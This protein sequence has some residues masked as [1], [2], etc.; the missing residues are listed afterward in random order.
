MLKRDNI[1]LR[2]HHLLCLYGF[3]GL[4]YSE[5]FVENM[6]A[7]IDRIRE[8]P[9]IEIEVV[10]GIDDICAKCPHNVENSCSKPRRNVEEFDREIVGRLGIDIGRKVESK[11]LLNLVEK[12]IQPEELPAICKGCEWLELGFCEEGLRKKNWSR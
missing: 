6:Q 9:S 5:E 2:A 1:K 10:N 3:R 4:G 7:I 8:N 12:R 11:T